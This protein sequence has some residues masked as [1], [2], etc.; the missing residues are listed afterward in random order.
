MATAPKTTEVQQD[1]EA[2]T[3]A[4]D[5][6]KEIAEVREAGSVTSVAYVPVALITGTAMPNSRHFNLVNK[7]Q[8]RTIATLQVASGVNPAAGAETA[9]PI[10]GNASVAVGD[11]LEWQSVHDGTGLVDPGGL[12][13]VVIT[14]GNIAA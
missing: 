5:A 11:V 3:I 4:A 7:T 1:T 6:N 10:T 12:V 2:V 14:R 8:S 9:I 13:R